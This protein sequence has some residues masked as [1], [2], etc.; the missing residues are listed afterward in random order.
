M[1]LKFI[2]ASQC[3][4]HKTSNNSLQPNLHFASLPKQISGYTTAA[5]GEQRT[6]RSAGEQVRAVQNY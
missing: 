4:E 2:S 6:A 5:K 3:A 1:S